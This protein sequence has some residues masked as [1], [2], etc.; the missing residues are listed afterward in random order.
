MGD[1]STPGQSTEILIALGRKKSLEKECPQVNG[2][3][4]RPFFKA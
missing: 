1:W 2:P 3:T 4:E